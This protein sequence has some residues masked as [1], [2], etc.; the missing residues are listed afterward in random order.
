M[1]QYSSLQE[2]AQVFQTRQYTVDFYELQRRARAYAA[3]APAAIA[4]VGPSTSGKTTLIEKCIHILSSCGLKVGAI[5]AH[6]K[7]QF[8]ID[9]P[10]KDSYRFTEAGSV[11]TLV[12]APGKLALTKRTEHE[13]TFSELLSYMDDCELVLVEGYRHNGLPTIELLR[14]GVVD[15][16]DSLA[17]TR[18]AREETLALATDCN[19]EEI[20]SVRQGR[21]L[22]VLPL[23]EPELI[24]SFIVQL[25]SL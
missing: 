9:T 6:T 14:R 18:I 16:H 22:C 13:P 11:C 17:L 4:L 12:S 1:K 2:L 24:A 5:K 23:K 7:R 10:G 15:V 21:N 3:C 25:F 19:A 20:E 8:D